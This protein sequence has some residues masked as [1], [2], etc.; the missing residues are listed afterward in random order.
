MITH[1]FNTV[2][3]FLS[4]IFYMNCVYDS[5]NLLK[6]TLVWLCDFSLDLYH[7]KKQHYID[8]SLAAS[9]LARWI[10]GE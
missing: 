3:L 2:R 8:Y 5:K 9:K 4:S 1:N 6:V 10:G 7:C